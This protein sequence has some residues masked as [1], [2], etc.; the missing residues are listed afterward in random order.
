ML[1]LCDSSFVCCLFWQNPEKI[2]IAFQWLSGNSRMTLKKR[3]TLFYCS[4]N[5]KK[6]IVVATSTHSFT[7]VCEELLAK[8]SSNQQSHREGYHNNLKR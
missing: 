2:M 5:Y 3:L 8:N 4:Y 7:R 6:Y 1:H